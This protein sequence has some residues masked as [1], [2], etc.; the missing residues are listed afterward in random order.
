ML[1]V[2][3]KPPNGPYALAA[4]YTDPATSGIARVAL[5]YQPTP[6]SDERVIQ[7]RPNAAGVARAS[8]TIGG[9]AVSF[10]CK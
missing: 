2:E 8:A 6:T 3:A 4:L 10:T 1:S 5:L 7:G 9:S